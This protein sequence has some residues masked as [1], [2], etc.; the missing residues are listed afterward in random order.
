MASME[1][2]HNKTRAPGNRLLVDQAKS[3]HTE[4][5]VISTNMAAA[6]P[7]LGYLPTDILEEILDL[8]PI[9]SIG[10]FRSV[11]KSLFSLLAIK[12]NLPK[13]RHYPCILNFPT[14]Y[15]MESS[16]DKGLFTGVVLSQYSGGDDV[17]NQ[18]YRA[19]D[20][21]LL[22]A[23]GQSRHCSFLGSCNGLVVLRVSDLFCSAKQE[24]T[25]VWNPFTGISRKLPHR[26][27]YS[28][29]F[30]YG[31]GYVS[32]SNDYK[33]FAATGPDLDPRPEDFKV[34]IFSLKTGSW[35]KLKITLGVYFQYIQWLLGMGLFLNGALLWRPRESSSWGEKGE[36]TIVAI[37][38]DLE[39]EKFYLL[40]GPPIQ[41]SRGY[42]S[43]LGVVG[44]YLCFSHIDGYKNNI[45]VMKEYCDEASWVPF[46]SYTFTGF[47][48]PYQSGDGKEREGR[49]E[50]VC[51]FIPQYFKD[52]RYMLLQFGYDLHVLKW[53]N[54]LE[55]S[56][57]AEKYSKKIKF[58]RALGV[59]YA[60]VPYAQTLASPYAT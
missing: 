47:T 18:G 7:N 31:F 41:I 53:D 23:P 19:P 15:G 2:K 14:S 37:A 60:G 42:G 50:Y 44:E 38:F 16:D 27:Y 5:P 52:G 40:P 3:T 54:N 49:V 1:K 26:N 13:L 46:I 6:A 35:K 28:Y 9:E 36:L 33:V 17:K 57:E 10:R 43:R 21:L 59:P 58:G 51:D 34:E 22:A 12:F 56:D 48:C 8:L 20:E 55:E 11:S 4:Q 39:K 29:G 25:F 32:A 24:E 45:W 30:F